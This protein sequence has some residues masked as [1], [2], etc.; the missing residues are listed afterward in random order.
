MFG[1]LKVPHVMKIRG[2]KHFHIETW[3]ELSNL[4]N[5]VIDEFLEEKSSTN[6]LKL[7]LEIKPLKH[8]S[9]HIGFWQWIFLLVK[10]RDYY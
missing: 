2:E 1:L 5:I 4:Y 9:T 10:I 8:C 7:E 3:K 6:V